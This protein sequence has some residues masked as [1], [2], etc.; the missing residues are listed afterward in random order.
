VDVISSVEYRS[1]GIILQIEPIVFSDNRIDLTISQEVSSALPTAGPISSPTF[2]NTSVTTQLS[3]ED[4]ATAVI[5]GLIQDNVTREERGIP[6]LKDVP[7]LGRAFSTETQSV[8]RSELVILI[9]AYILRD[10][11]QKAALANTLSAQI[12]R[13]LRTDNLVTLRPRFFP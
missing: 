11:S 5:G 12:D 8:D 13:T 4:G 2:A 10:K 9:T 1:T 7:L 6:F 3:L